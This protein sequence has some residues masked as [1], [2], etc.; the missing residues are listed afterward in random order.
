MKSCNSPL[1]QICNIAPP[2]QVPLSP[3]LPSP[4]GQTTGAT[5]ARVQVDPG[6]QTS[7][8]GGEW[9]LPG[10]ATEKGRIASVQVRFLSLLRELHTACPA[11]SVGRVCVD[12]RAHLQ[13]LRQLSPGVCKL[14]VTGRNLCLICG[15]S[16]LEERSAHQCTHAQHSE[17]ERG[18]RPPAAHGP[19][20]SI[21]VPAPALQFALCVTLGKSLEALPFCSVKGQ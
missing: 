2:L 18:V 17:G 20:A 8:A 12:V 10:L 1:I 9:C 3:A 21:W 11:A 19:R 13:G 5:S 15:L 14:H 4:A 16:L 6:S 7:A